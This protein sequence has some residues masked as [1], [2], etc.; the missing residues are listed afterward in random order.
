MLDFWVKFNEIDLYVEHEVDN[1]IIVGKIFLLTTREDDVEGVEF[2]GEGDA[3]GVES[4]GE[5]DLERVESVGEGDVG[6]V[7]VDG[8]G[9]S[10]IGIEVDEYGGVE[11]GVDNVVDEYA[12]D[13][14]TSDG[15]D[16]VAAASNGEKEYGNKTEVGDS[17][18]HESLVGFDEDEEHEDSEKRRIK[19]PLYSDKLKFSLGMLFKDEKKF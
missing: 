8:E 2:D 1:L 9:V 13:F 19:F 3:E 6:G 17:D 10:P 16:N 18:E 5:G 4:D 7:Q 14:A 11:N 15:V 12:S